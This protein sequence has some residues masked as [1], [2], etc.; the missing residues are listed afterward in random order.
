M[1]ACD[2]AACRDV[3]VDD[4]DGWRLCRKHRRDHELMRQGADPEPDP[5]WPTGPWRSSLDVDEAAVELA[6]RGYQLPR[7]L[8]RA[9]H[10]EVVR[11]LHRL[12]LNDQE[13][14]ARCGLTSRNV[15][16]IRQT[17]GLPAFSDPGV[18]VAA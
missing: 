17:L 4:V 2:Y 6:S 7:R 1:R 18:R 3:D 10:L 15:L 14:E 12:G 16:R 11:R 5:G 13:I 9:E 8:G